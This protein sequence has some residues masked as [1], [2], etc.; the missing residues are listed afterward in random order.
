MILGVAYKADIDDIRESPALDVIR[1]LKQ[2]GA[3]VVYHDPLVEDNPELEQTPR[4]ELTRESLSGCDC[5]A[6]ITGHSGV[7]YEFVVEQIPALVDTRNVLKGHRSPKIVR[8]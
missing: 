7:D 1:L 6:I 5:A 3:E 2:K 8:L 4:V